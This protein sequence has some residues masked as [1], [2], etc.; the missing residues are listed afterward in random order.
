MYADHAT[1]WQQIA[2]SGATPG[3]KGL[4]RSR[5]ER[6]LA[7]QLVPEKARELVKQQ[8]LDSGTGDVVGSTDKGRGY[9]I[10][11]NQYEDEELEALLPE[12]TDTIDI[13]KFVP[14]C[15]IDERYLDSPYPASHMIEIKFTLPADFPI[16]GISAVQP[17]V[18]KQADPKRA[19][20][21]AGLAVKVT[22][23]FFLVGLSAIDTDMQRN[24]QLLKEWPWF[25]VQ[26]AY[27]HR[28]ALL[29]IE[30]GAPGE[31]AFQEAFTAWGGT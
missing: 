15:E 4:A 30:K 24:L 5:K 2:S 7:L 16:G 22:P 17:I 26:V 19:A 20:P 6:V 12:S 11:R 9:E 25:G 10:G 1:K 18:M 27:S 28:R 13:E 31:R 21:L 8:Q 14:R 29:A 3:H 23:A